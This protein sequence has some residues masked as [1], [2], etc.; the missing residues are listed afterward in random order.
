MFQVQKCLGGDWGDLVPHRL[1]IFNML[2]IKIRPFL[3][4]D[5]RRKTCPCNQTTCM[6][7]S[8]ELSSAKLSLTFPIL[9][10]LTALVDSQEQPSL[11]DVN[12][13]GNSRI[14]F[15]H[16]ILRDLFLVIMSSWFTSKYSGRIISRNLSD[17]HLLPHLLRITWSLHQKILG[18]QFS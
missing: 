8:P 18:N 17:L 12:T 3:G 13:I 10:K 7:F 14:T 1:H 5:V 15:H 11:A 9:S 6:H 4:G 2:A 16:F